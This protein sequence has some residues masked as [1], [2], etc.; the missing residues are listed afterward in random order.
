[1]RI[2]YTN[3]LTALSFIIILFSGSQAILR[4]CGRVLVLFVLPLLDV[5]M[6]GKVDSEHIL[7]L[8]S[9]NFVGAL[10]AVA[11]SVV[12]LKVLYVLIFKFKIIFVTN[13]KLTAVYVFRFYKE[14]IIIDEIKSV[15]WK[16]WSVKPY[17]FISVTISDNSNIITISDFEFENFHTIVAQILGKN[18]TDNSLP[19]FKSQAKQN[20]FL[21]CFIVFAS[22]ILLFYT[23]PNIYMN[24]ASKYSYLILVISVLTMVVSIKRIYE[25]R[26]AA[27]LS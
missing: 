25:Y 18:Y 11:Y 23:M 15:E 6:T 13:N 1:M 26:K 3:I 22:L 10:F 4:I 8:D 2:G 16:S 5:F 27:N 19:Y 9:F 24:N 14:T 20:S 17:S 21:S 12:M 7:S